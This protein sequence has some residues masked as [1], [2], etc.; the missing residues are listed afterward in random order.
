MIDE[1]SEVA[2]DASLGCIQSVVA[3]SAAVPTVAGS[4]KK[5][6]ERLKQPFGNPKLDMSRLDVSLEGH[7]SVKNLKNALMEEE[8]SLIHI[9]EP[10]RH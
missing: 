5:R 3:E 6:I 1:Y 10:T 8:L 7:D 9:S 2:M 4:V